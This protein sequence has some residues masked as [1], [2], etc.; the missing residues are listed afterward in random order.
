MSAWQTI[1]SIPA[2]PIESDNDPRKV[3]VF[4]ADGGPDGKGAIDFGWAHLRKDGTKSVRA[5]GYNGRHW[6]ITHWSELPPPPQKG[7]SNARFI[8]GPKETR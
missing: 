4:I 7:E 6:D 3:L 1:D 8:A 2:E 5:A